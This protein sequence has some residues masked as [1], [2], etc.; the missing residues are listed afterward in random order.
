VSYRI[1]ALP[2]ISAYFERERSLRL[3]LGLLN[4][5]ILVLLAVYV[6]VVSHFI[7]ENDR[8]EIAILKSRAPRRSRYSSST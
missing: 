4:A 8:N 3:I 1:A 2:L 5:P 7:V 6:Y